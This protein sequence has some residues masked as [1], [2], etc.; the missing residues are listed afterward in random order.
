MNAS[1]FGVRP[2][3]SFGV[4]CCMCSQ[5]SFFPASFVPLG[6]VG[7]AAAPQPSVAAPAG[8]LVYRQYPAAPAYPQQP[9]YAILRQNQDVGLD[10][11]YYE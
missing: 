9:F 2:E 7:A 1:T 6:G 10:S 5:Y 4:Q 3:R 8:A 11:Y